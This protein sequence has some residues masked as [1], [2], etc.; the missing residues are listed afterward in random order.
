[1]V[2]QFRRQ[3]ILLIFF[4]FFLFCSSFPGRAGETFPSKS[5]QEKV[6]F[7]FSMSEKDLSFSARKEL[8]ETL[9]NEEQQAVLDEYLSRKKSHEARIYYH[10]R[11][12]PEVF[13]KMVYQDKGMNKEQQANFTTNYGNAL[14]AGM[15]VADTIYKS[16]NYGNGKNLVEV[17]VPAGVPH[18][19]D[20]QLSFLGFVP[21][22]VDK[23]LKIKAVIEYDTA[24]GFSVIKTDPS[25]QS[26]DDLMK[27]IIF[28][29]FS[30]L[31]AN[32]DQLTDEE[33]TSTFMPA[34][35]IIPVANFQENFVV[36]LREFMKK[37]SL[38]SPLLSGTGCFRELTE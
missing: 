26:E 23:K 11:M 25:D 28:R 3:K 24:Y 2:P 16:A 19:S 29:P 22:H 35:K 37:R 7:L 1:M 33:I 30:G 13:R 10:W 6:D 31:K 38:E 5:A 9:T 15:Y 17:V 20:G 12:Q 34:M 32:G 4:F 8:I 14:G 27:K 36:Q 21:K 18:V